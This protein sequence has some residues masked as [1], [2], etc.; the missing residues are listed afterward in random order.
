MLNTPNNYY[1]TA[2]QFWNEYN[3]P[4][5]DAAIDRGDKFIMATP[6][7]DKT[8]YTATNQLTGYGREY[9]YLKANGYKLVNGEMVK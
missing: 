5:L 9:K 4:F 3:K 6:I 2:E 1:I 7:N 8:I